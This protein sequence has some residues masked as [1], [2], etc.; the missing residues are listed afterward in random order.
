MFYTVVINLQLSTGVPLLYNLYH[1]CATGQDINTFFS[2][3]E[4]IKDTPFLGLHSLTDRYT[5]MCI[6]EIYHAGCCTMIDHVGKMSR[7]HS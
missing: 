4:K 7:K 1:V 6:L 3:L 5:C 2:L